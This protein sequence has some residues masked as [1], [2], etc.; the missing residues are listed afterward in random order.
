MI[1]PEHLRHFPRATLVIA[2]DTVLAKFF[3][4]GGDSLEEL[5]G[6]AVAR[7]PLQDAEGTF[8]SSDGS[9]V[10]GP[11]SD[12]DDRPR[13]ERFVQEIVSRTAELVREHDIANVHVVMP[14][15]VEHLYAAGL[16]ADIAAKLGQRLHLDLMKYP[17]LE[18][19]ERLLQD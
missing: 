6:V 1:L 2:S 5:D 8:T 10:A 19:I 13:L 4:A 11:A 14:P 9:R 7:E 12:I 18:I 17:P 3:L 15:E 16:P